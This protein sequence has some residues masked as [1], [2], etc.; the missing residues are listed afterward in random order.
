MEE[1]D[2]AQ[3]QSSFHGN[4]LKKFVKD[5]KGWWTPA[6]GQ[7]TVKEKFRDHTLR[8]WKEALRGRQ[9]KGVRFE[10]EEEDGDSTEE[11]G[12]TIEGNPMET[13]IEGDDRATPGQT[14]YETVLRD[15][16]P[17]TGI[18]VVL[19]YWDGKT[20]YLGKEKR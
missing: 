5:D 14:F 12:N 9:G 2:G 17:K 16:K 13:L 10:E 8:N 6:D 1:L 4:R 15:F 18:E 19:P 20:P 11:N 7:D 3:L